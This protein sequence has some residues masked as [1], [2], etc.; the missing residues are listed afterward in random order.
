MRHTWTRKLW[1]RGRH[2]LIV[3]A[4]LF[5]I[6]PARSYGQEDTAES[7]PT[8][9]AVGKLITVVKD[10]LRRVDESPASDLLPP[11]SKAT[12]TLKTSLVKQKSGRLVLFVISIGKETKE[13]LAQIVKLELVPPVRRPF[14]PR[15]APYPPVAD[16]LAEAIMQ[17]A[18]ATADAG[19]TP[20]ALTLHKLTATVRFGVSSDS[21][22]GLGFEILPLSLEAGQRAG[23]QAIQELVVEFEERR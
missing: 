12:L 5:A 15:V 10:T 19:L 2:V 7:S 11:M 20:P 16:V 21:K 13:E 8:Q 14:R 17:S 6:S 1:E 3:L 23:R 9:V 4:V 18:L 22:A